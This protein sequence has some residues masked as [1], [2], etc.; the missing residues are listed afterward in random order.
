MHGQFRDLKC[1]GD[2]G[3][4]YGGGRRIR[5]HPPIQNRLLQTPAI[6][7]HSHLTLYHHIHMFVFLSLLFNKTLMYFDYMYL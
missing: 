7:H 2:A 6:T 5:A 3:G 4:V 1:H